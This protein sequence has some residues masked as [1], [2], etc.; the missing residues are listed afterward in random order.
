[1]KVEKQVTFQVLPGALPHCPW[2]D[3]EL[4][5]LSGRS[6]TVTVGAI[7]L[8][9]QCLG[10]GIFT[11]AKTLEIRRATD[12]EVEQTIEGLRRQGDLTAAR[13]IEVCLKTRNA[14][15]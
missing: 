5:A 1:M 7:S 14:R 8:C 6:S 10:I 3:V 15:V 11:N 2:C 13:L 4:H 12:V 9:D